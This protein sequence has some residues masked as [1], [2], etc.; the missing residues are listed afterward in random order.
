M[1]RSL[2]SERVRAAMINAVLNTLIDEPDIS[3]IS[4]SV[5]AVSYDKGEPVPLF[6]APQGAVVRGRL[7]L[8]LSKKTF[9]DLKV[10]PAEAQ[11]SLQGAHQNT[12]ITF[13]SSLIEHI[14]GIGHDG[15]AISGEQF[16]PFLGTPIVTP[17]KEKTTPALRV[18]RGGGA[19]N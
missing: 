18:I 12:V 17:V 15:L 4:V 2:R 16:I 14:T 1:M 13:P 19:K 10:G 5:Q 9:S 7:T 6:Y 8:T 3:K 11:F